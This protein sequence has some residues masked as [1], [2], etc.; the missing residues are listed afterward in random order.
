M[1]CTFNAGL[2]IQNHL[3]RVQLNLPGLLHRQ[4]HLIETSRLDYFREDGEKHDVVLMNEEWPILPSVKLARG[5]GIMV[6]VCREHSTHSSQKRL[7]PHPPRK[8]SHVLSSTRPAN[9]SP[10][11]LRPNTL[12]P[13]FARTYCTQT[14]VRA[15]EATFSGIDSANITLEPPRMMG[16][17]EILHEDEKLSFVGR[18][19][20]RLL[21]QR[22]VEEKKIHPSLYEELSEEASDHYSLQNAELSRLKRGS[23]YCPTRNAIILQKTSA[24]QSKIEVVLLAR[25]GVGQPATPR[26]AYIGRSWPAISYNMQVDDGEKHF[27]LPMKAILPYRWIKGKNRGKHTMMTWC[28][29]GLVAGSS[30]LYHCIDQKDTPH[31]YDGLSGHLLS[32]VAVEYMKECT[33]I[34]P[35]KSPF[36]GRNASSRVRQLI[37]DLAPRPMSSYTGSI[38]G[39]SDLFFRMN[40]SYFQKIFSPRDY[41]SICVQPSVESIRNS[42]NSMAWKRIFIVVGS[43]C[44][45]GAASFELSSRLGNFKYEARVVMAL[46]V[47][48]DETDPS[49]FC[50]VRY[51][52]YGGGYSNWW[53][54]DRGPHSKMM[55][56]QHVHS[57]SRQSDEFPSLPDGAFQYVTLYVRAENDI[58]ES[59]HLDFFRS[60]GIQCQVFCNCCEINPLIISGQKNVNKKECMTD[61]CKNKEKYI[62][63]KLGCSSRVCG[64]CFDSYNKERTPVFLTPKQSVVMENGIE[65]NDGNNGDNEDDDDY[66]DCMECQW[67]PDDEDYCSEGA[68]EDDDDLLESDEYTVSNNDDAD[69]G[70]ENEDEELSSMLHQEE[71]EEAEDQEG[72]CEGND[73]PDYFLDDASTDSSVLLQD[74]FDDIS[75]DGS[76]L[77]YEQDDTRKGWKKRRKTISEK[78]SENATKIGV[79]VESC[80]SSVD[81]LMQNYVSFS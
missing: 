29:C 50:G 69:N 10:C 57:H 59:Y 37:D 52:R 21:A 7:Y 27:G 70:D 56:T 5:K 13:L 64:D 3:R 38:N 24:E 54:Q 18:S 22:M 48:E 76:D 73:G 68:D 32:H 35:G 80:P 40:M 66:R 42:P 34:T 61:G 63:G 6:L 28:V 53:R 65:E 36:S 77:E 20:I 2:V 55:M 8:P 16:L 14:S 45:K 43:S 25:N 33:I 79:D 44:P 62:C 9:L 58:S 74:S 12:K 60:I 41:P 78:M 31:R 1:S 81:C 72:D 30:E 51:S 49:K 39:H 17:S 75:S 71:E 19:D 11:R 15:M 46:S 67:H 4:L 26:H 23:T 47:N